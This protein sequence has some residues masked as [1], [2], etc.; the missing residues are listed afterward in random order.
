MH[1]K[2]VKNILSPKNCMN[3]YRG[4]SHGCIYCDSRSTVYGMDHDFE[5]IEVKQNALELL[6]YSLK[7]KRKKCMISTGSMCDP[8]I[9][10]EEELEYTRKSLELIEK[11]GYGISI[12]TKSNRILR[13][14]E[15]LKRINKKTKTVVELTLTTYDEELCKKLEPNVSTTKE[16]VEVLNMM[17]DH[18]I[19]T[20]VWLGPFLPF[21]N[22]TEENLKGLLD[23]CIEAKVKGIICF[24]IG[25]TLREGNREYFY[26]KLDEL[27]PGLKE[28]YIKMYHKNYAIAGR[29]QE[30]LYQ[31]FVSECK[32]HNILYDMNEIFAYLNEFPDKDE[33]ISF[34]E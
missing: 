28:T 16:R 33:Q 5:D 32:K 26:Q 12:L 29:E 14:L 23:Y 10:L 18:H 13:D 7:S 9:H 8:Y 4:C 34:F 24:G 11:Y 21:I 6:E 25:L 1:Y 31:Y 17:R 20:V 15:L 2:N 27:F 19:P 3:I 30:K 22:D